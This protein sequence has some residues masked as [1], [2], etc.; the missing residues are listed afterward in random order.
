MPQLFD[1]VKNLQTFCSS[2]VYNLLTLKFSQN[3]APN[4]KI[5]SFYKLLANRN[6]FL[7]KEAQHLHFFESANY[8][9]RL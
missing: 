2:D 4:K 1:L 3:G 9:I 5:A 8:A 6:R 7:N